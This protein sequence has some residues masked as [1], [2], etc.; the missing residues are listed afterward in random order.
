MKKN[1]SLHLI[2]LFLFCFFS[3]LNGQNN[4]S[5]GGVPG[6]EA[7][8]I[9]EKVSGIGSSS[10]YGWVDHSGKN[11]SLSIGGTTNF[12]NNKIRYY[13]FHPSLE[14]NPNKLEF[15]LP[16]K[17]LAQSS[18]L[19]VFC[20]KSNFEKERHL[21]TLKGQETK[22]NIVGTDNIYSG[23]ERLLE[24]K[25]LDYGSTYGMDLNYHE[26]E[27]K[28]VFEAR[29]ARIVTYS[30][31]NKP[32]HSFWGVSKKSK[33]Y[34]GDDYYPKEYLEDNQTTIK[35]VFEV[36]DGY[37]PEFLVYNRFLSPLE[38]IKINSYLALKYG[39]SLSGMYIL[40]DNHL[41]WNY[42]EN[43][44]YNS[45]I[46]GIYRDDASGIEQLTSTTSYEESPDYSY[47]N[48]SYSIKD[49]LYVS[50]KRLLSIAKEPANTFLKDKSYILYGDN[51]APISLQ[52]RSVLGA[53]TMGRVWQIS[54]NTGQEISEETKLKW[55]VEN[56]TMKEENKWKTSF[57]QEDSLEFKAA[58]AVSENSLRG[59]MGYLS[60][61]GSKIPLGTEVYIKLGSN[62]KTASGN[63]DYGII[64]KDGNVYALSKGNI[65]TDKLLG[66]L[67]EN[68]IIEIYKYKDL[69]RLVHRNE[70]SVLKIEKITIS[71]GDIGK[72]YYAG[73]EIKNRGIGDCIISSIEHGGFVNTGSELEL[74]YSKATDFTSE[75]KAN[76]FLLIDHSG[77]GNFKANDVE[78]IF[79]NE[80]DLSRSKLKF[81]N[82]FWDSDNNGRESFTFGYRETN[83]L[84]IIDEKDP[85]CSG[86]TSNKD[87][88]IKIT[89]QSGNGP[90][91]Y[92]VAN[93]KDSSVIIEEGE[94]SGKEIIIKSL[95]AGEYIVTLSDQ[96]E[97]VIKE[98]ILNG[99]CIKPPIPDPPYP[100]IKLLKVYDIPGHEGQDF[101]IEVNS[102]YPSEVSVMIYNI[103]GNLLW[104]KDDKNQLLQHKFTTSLLLSGYYTVT[105]ILRDGTQDTVKIHIIP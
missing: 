89:I 52:K 98:I 10:Q 19:G 74:S 24:P 31:M 105:A 9:T 21:Y 5:P 38:R 37:I 76:Y 70:T 22:S 63:W 72:A 13:N 94:T 64:I 86:M 29:S 59:S 85:T 61:K 27:K 45:R 65:R 20:A 77:T 49:T 71:E 35:D 2:F 79:C 75:K 90:Y 36:F 14:L 53:S 87:G 4:V 95:N 50:E 26:K 47:I 73:I 40:S 60:M 48:D 92:K 93:K 16:G 32:E 41:A 62:Q 39:L 25:D 96:S 101:T 69:F 83:L 1:Y 34:L 56:F 68:S 8:F 91:R 78:Y 6:V 66:A 97:M 88:E 104:E 17:S 33:F 3:L 84:A 28:D 80:V 51:N 12:K 57:L 23:E 82:I 55:N 43:I 67:T 18:V 58:Y 7:W 102:K 30:R 54:T 15:S 100:D 99:S 46:T 103:A 44:N 81:N 42:N 11:L